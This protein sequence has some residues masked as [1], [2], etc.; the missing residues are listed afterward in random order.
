MRASHWSE[1]LARAGQNALNETHKTIPRSARVTRRPRNGFVRLRD[2]RERRRTIQRQRGICEGNS[3][4]VLDSKEGGVYDVSR[5][6][7]T[8]CDRVVD[9]QEMFKA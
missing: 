4:K 6:S 5:V 7:L 8:E 3:E 9:G 1:A 2:R